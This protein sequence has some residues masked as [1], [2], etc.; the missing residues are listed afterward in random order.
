MRGRWVVRGC[1]AIGADREAEEHGFGPW[2]AAW[3]CPGG[4]R[5]APTPLGLDSAPMKGAIALVGSGEFTPALEAIDRELLAATGRARPRGAVLPT[6]SAPDGEDGFLR[7]AE[8]GPPHSGA[9]RGPRPGGHPAFPSDA[10]AGTAVDRAIHEAHARGAVVVGC[11]AGAIV[12]ADRRLRVRRRVP[13]PPRRQPA[14]RP[15]PPPPR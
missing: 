1:R 13:S 14:L 15:V 4:S 6:A 5:S 9:P 12:L 10:L 7:W 2:H 3:S 11:S 8:V